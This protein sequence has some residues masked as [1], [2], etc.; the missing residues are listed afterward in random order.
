MSKRKF[1]SRKSGDK[2]K[3]LRPPKTRKIQPVPAPTPKVET[4]PMVVEIEVLEGLMS[5]VKKEIRHHFGDQIQILSE[6]ET[7]LILN[8]SGRLKAL[9]SLR[10]VVAVYHVQHFNVP[11][12]KAL[13]GHQHFHAMLDQIKVIRGM[14]P[15]GMFE[16]FRISAAGENSSVFARLK[17]EVREYTGMDV[18]DDADLLLRVRPSVVQTGGWEVLTRISPRP[19]SA[20][21]WRVTDMHGALNAC[22]A[23]AM[24]ELTQPKPDDRYLNLMCGSGTLMVERMLKMSA[25]VAV[26]IDIDDFALEAS[27]ENLEAS[28]QRQNVFLSKMDATQTGFGADTF[29][30]IVVDFPYGQKIG[31]SEENPALYAASLK[32]AARIATADACLVVITHQM[33]SFEGVVDAQRKWRYERTLQVNQG[34]LHPKIY[35]LERNG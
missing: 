9:L 4:P 6:D 26:G 33:K 17:S 25:E 20:R 19:L 18:E 28:H 22:L 3:K 27:V 30:K 12:P 31:S 8:Y 21:D 7:T 13:L 5:L 34:G 10:M 15:K 29:N 32:E 1:Q 35:V 16:T 2:R 14:H 11:R 23:A 24:V